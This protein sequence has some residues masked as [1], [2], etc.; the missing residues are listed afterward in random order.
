ME[1]LEPKE[2]GGMALWLRLSA[3]LL[4]LQA[5]VVIRNVMHIILQAC[6][7]MAVGKLRTFYVMQ[8]QQDASVDAHEWL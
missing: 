1:L 3:I 8:E 6:E 7:S 4:M 5:T 2:E